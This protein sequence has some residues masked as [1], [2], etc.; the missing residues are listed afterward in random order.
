MFTIDA[1]AL[2]NTIKSYILTDIYGKMSLEKQINSLK[3]NIFEIDFS[4]YKTGIYF[5]RLD[6]ENQGIIFRKIIKK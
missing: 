5:L 4:K 1:S 6:T 2:T 3:N